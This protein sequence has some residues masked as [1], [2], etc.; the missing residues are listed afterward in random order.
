[1]THLSDFCV[2]CEAGVQLH[3]FACVYPVFLAL[4]TKISILPL[5]NFHDTLVKNQLT[6]NMCLFLFLF[7]FLGPHMQHMEVPRLGAESD[8]QLLAHTTATA[9]PDLSHVFNLHHSSWQHRIFNPLSKARDWTCILMVTSCVCY[10]WPTM[11]T[12]VCIS[13]LSVLLCCS[14]CMPA[15]QLS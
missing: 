7:C 2:C 13:R 11:G 15:P 1:M 9:M 3:S 5:W 14:I 6:I 4:F 8:L 10:H 12:P